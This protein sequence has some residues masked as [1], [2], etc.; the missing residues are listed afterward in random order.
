MNRGPR[1]NPAGLGTGIG[2]GLEL[3]LASLMTVV[4]SLGLVFGA[5]IA[6]IVGLHVESIIASPSAGG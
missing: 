6:V 3:I 2:A 4:L 5:G 1:R